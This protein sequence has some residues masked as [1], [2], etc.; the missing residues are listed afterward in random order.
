MLLLIYTYRDCLSI[1]GV[2]QAGEWVLSAMDDRV[3]NLHMQVRIWITRSSVNRLPH[4][5]SNVSNSRLYPLYAPLNSRLE[6]PDTTTMALDPTIS[7]QLASPMQVIFCL[8]EKNT[9]KINSHRWFFS[10]FCRL[11]QPNICVLLDVGTRPGPKSLYRLWKTL[12]PHH[13][14]LTRYSVKLIDA[15]ISFDL[16]SNVGGACGEVAVYKGK[17]WIGL[18]NPLGMLNGWFS[19]HSPLIGTP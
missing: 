2:F 5:Y 17:W 10:A 4:I 6:T 16:N 19:Y 11:L 1:L 3:L 12:V 9:K 18:L 7:F 8:K 13:L 14:I 15:T